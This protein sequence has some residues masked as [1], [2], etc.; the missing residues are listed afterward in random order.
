M[1][2]NALGARVPVVPVADTLRTLPA[3]P[4]S[5]GTSRAFQGQD[6]AGTVWRLQVA[7]DRETLRTVVLGDTWLVGVAQLPDAG[8]PALPPLL[9]LRDAVD[10]FGHIQAAGSLVTTLIT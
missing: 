9:P 6:S 1:A 5:L 8:V 2:T 3:P 7:P 10:A 4:T